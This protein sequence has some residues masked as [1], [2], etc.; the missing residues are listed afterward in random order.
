MFFITV[1]LQQ[2]YIEEI[3]YVI[4]VQKKTLYALRIEV[5]SYTTKSIMV[6]YFMES[7]VKY[8]SCIYFLSYFSLY[9]NLVNILQY[10]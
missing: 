3:W 1:I 4:Q 10:T 9:F 8:G 6:H 7:K 2:I 5:A